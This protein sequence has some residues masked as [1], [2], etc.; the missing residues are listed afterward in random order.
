MKN[1]ILVAV[2]VMSFGAAVAQPAEAAIWGSPQST[3]RSGPYD[4]TGNGPHYTW[5]GGG[6]G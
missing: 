5:G 3:H 1:L 6:G 4:N 2:A